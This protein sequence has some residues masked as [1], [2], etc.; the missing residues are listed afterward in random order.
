MSIRVTTWAIEMQRILN[1]NGVELEELFAYVDDLR[2][3]LKALIE[4][5]KFCSSCKE[6]YPCKTQ[7]KIDLE[8]GESDA[9][10]TA[11]V[12]RDIFNSIEKDL[13]FTIELEEDFEDSWLPTLDTKLKMELKDIG[14]E[15]SLG[16]TATRHPT[17]NAAAITEPEPEPEPVLAQQITYSFY[18][19]PLGSSFTIIETP[20]SSYQSK[21][22]SLS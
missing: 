18:S 17:P 15:G 20:A 10:R 5:N 8:S 7:E 19:K 13:K 21:K 11:R 9:K 16:N 4:G 22:A 2:S 6:L 3:F 12:L 14:P 1:E